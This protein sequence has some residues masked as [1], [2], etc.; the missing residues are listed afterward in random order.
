M[1][2]ILSIILLGVL[3]GCVTYSLPTIK[4]H[5]SILEGEQAFVLLRITYEFEDGTP[6]EEFYF[7]DASANISIGLGS[8]LA[9]GKVKRVP[10]RFLSD[11]TRTQGW[12]YLILEPGT[13]HLAFQGPQTGSLWQWEKELRHAPRFRVNLPKNKSLVYIGTL[14]LYC[15]KIKWAFIG[16]GCRTFDRERLVVRNEE[17]MAEELATEVLSGLGSPQTLL[18]ESFIK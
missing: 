5:T 6:V 7:K 16:N 1:R 3:T 8:F 15:S 4:E 18:M 10:Q 9:G 11:E 12:S 2:F 14:H 17:S 13:Y